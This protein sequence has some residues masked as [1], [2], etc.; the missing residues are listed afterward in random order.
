VEANK[1][2]ITGAAT[3]VGAAIAMKLAGHNKEIVIHYNKSK[4]QAENLKKNLIKKN[5]KVF[6]VQGNLTKEKDI[7]KIINFAKKKLKNFDCLIN[8]ASLFENDKITDFTSKKLGRSYKCKSQGACITYKKI[9]K[10]CF[11][12]K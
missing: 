4:T 1:I 10:I 2:I 5:A 7:D 8:N 11:K 6:L 9:F 12:R 3:R